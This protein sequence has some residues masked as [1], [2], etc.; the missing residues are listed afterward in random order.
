MIAQL[1]SS[2][3]QDMQGN[4]KEFS[5]LA[6]ELKN[7]SGKISEGLDEDASKSS[8]EFREALEMAIKELLTYVSCLSP[9]FHFLMLT[10]V[11]VL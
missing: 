5:E 10:T 8:G 7:L 6:D 9:H 1:T 3:S 4:R 11:L 2:P